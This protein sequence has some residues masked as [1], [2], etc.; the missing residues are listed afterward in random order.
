ML[1]SVSDIDP[2]LLKRAQQG[3]TAAVEQVLGTIV[4]GAK[5][6]RYRP[7][8]WLWIVAGIVGGV[9]V[10]GFAFA[11]FGEASSAPSF[12]APEITAGGF[13]KGLAIG[14]VAG[15]AIGWA[16]GRYRHSSRSSP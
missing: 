5:Q 14:V 3:D 11:Y 13:A 8:L 4:A 9:C 10:I 15:I 2:A 6:S 12:Q 7:T 16:L 1:A